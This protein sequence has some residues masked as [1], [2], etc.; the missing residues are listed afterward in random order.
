[1][2]TFDTMA[3]DSPTTGRTWTTPVMTPITRDTIPDLDTARTHATI[4][5]DELLTLENLPHRTRADTLRQQQIESHMS[6]LVGRIEVLVRADPEQMRVI[7]HLARLE[8]RYLI[9]RGEKRWTERDGQQKQLDRPLT[10]NLE[11][12]EWLRHCRTS[13]LDDYV[14]SIARP[15]F[16]DCGEDLRKR[17]MEAFANKYKGMPYPRRALTWDPSETA[18]QLDIERPVESRDFP[19]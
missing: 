6:H 4:L 9:A 13:S 5:D 8:V 10:E 11:I 12:P 16:S 14:S 2:P 1:M 7:E 18:R 19:I 15:S 3:D 17:A